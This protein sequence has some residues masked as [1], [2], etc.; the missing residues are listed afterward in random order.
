MSAD[1][2]RSMGPDDQDQVL[3]WEMAA[4]PPS[5]ESDWYSDDALGTEPPWEFP[6]SSEPAGDTPDTHDYSQ[7]SG[8]DRRSWRSITQHRHR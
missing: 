8:H 6:D 7:H 2:E 3:A 4:L 5:E 1:P